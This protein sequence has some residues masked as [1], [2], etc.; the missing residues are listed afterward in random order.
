MSRWE[1]ASR[2]RIRAFREGPFVLIVAE[3]E[4][5]N[6]GYEVDIAKSLLRIF[7]QQFNLLRRAKPGIFP[8][9]V[10][11]YRYAETVRYPED[12]DTITVHHADGTDRVD[13]EPT[14]KELASFVAAVRGGADRPALPAEAEE[15]IGL[16]SKLSFDEA[17]ANA[18]A[19]LPPSDAILADALARVQVL[20]IG[21]LFG[22]FAG[23]HHLFVRVSRT[24]T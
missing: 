22:G 16:S 17:F 5:P 14:G 24:I 10:T 8:Q 21:G 7:P 9:Y 4:L 13:I 19:N 3:G 23:F 6:P 12:Q 11:P 1:L 20:E 15:A 2:S 18:V